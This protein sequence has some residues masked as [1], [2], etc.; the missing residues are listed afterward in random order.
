MDSSSAFN[1]SYAS[2]VLNKI[3]NPLTVCGT[4]LHL[5]LPLTFC[6]IH[7]QLRNPK[8]LAMFACC[9]I[10]DTTYVPTKLTLHS[11]IHGIHG[12]FA[13][14]VYLHFGTCLKISFWNPGTYRHKIVRL[15]SAQ[16]GL[17]MSWPKWQSLNPHNFTKN[18]HR[19]NIFSN[20]SSGQQSLLKFRQKWLVNKSK[21]GWRKKPNPNTNFFL[22]FHIESRNNK[23]LFFEVL[24]TI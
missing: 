1:C 14:G 16:F 24:T 3:R 19:W 18:D 9:G 10:R 11:Y 21:F 15:S 20:L 12:S 4:R 6:G 7:L 2:S 23:I 22:Y 8:Q 5:R 13:R 17:V